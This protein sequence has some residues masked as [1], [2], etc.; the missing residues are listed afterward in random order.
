MPVSRSIFYGFGSWVGQQTGATT[1]SWWAQDP[2]TLKPP[3]DPTKLISNDLA[4]NPQAH[5]VAGLPVAQIEV[6][7]APPNG[8]STKIGPTFPTGST[9]NGCWLQSEL[10]AAL[11]GNQQPARIPGGAQCRDY[12]LTTVLYWDGPLANRRFWGFHVEINSEQA[13]SALVSIWPAG[14]S[15]VPGQLPA[16]AVW[17]D[18]A[19]QAHPIEPGFTQVGVGPQS[20]KIGAL[21]LDAPTVEGLQLAAPKLPSATGSDRFPHSAAYRR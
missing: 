1:C 2:T 20:P 14:T 7:D 16:T 3:F 12:E 15:L 21:F 11:P 17:L 9:T 6:D 18:L 13:P 8:G 4:K 5:R 10:Y 19:T